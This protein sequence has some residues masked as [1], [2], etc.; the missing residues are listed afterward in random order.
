[1]LV[2]HQL[3][4]LSLFVGT[5]FTPYVGQE[6]PTK[7]SSLIHGKHYDVITNTNTNI[8]VHNI[9]YNS[10]Q[11]Q[12]SQ[13]NTIHHPL[14]I[15]N[16]PTCSSFKEFLFTVALPTVHVSRSEQSNVV[17]LIRNSTC[18]YH[19]LELLQG[20]VISTIFLN[21]DS[22]LLYD[23]DRVIIYKDSHI[24]NSSVPSILR[25]F[26]D[27][28]RQQYRTKW[29]CREQPT[30]TVIERDNGDL[31]IAS[32]K[33]TTNFQRHINYFSRKAN[34]TIN[35]VDLQALSVSELIKTLHHTDVLMGVDHE[36][37]LL[38]ALM[39]RPNVVIRLCVIECNNATS[40]HLD[41]LAVNYVNHIIDIP[42][43]IVDGKVLSG[44]LRSRFI[45]E[46]SRGK[47]LAVRR[48]SKE[49]IDDLTDGFRKLYDL[50]V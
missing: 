9:Q 40:H 10:T 7:T 8:T 31:S 34:L 22:F 49:F 16:G 47:A 41:V 12:H 32:R 14:L 21:N 26:R 4:L 29:R 38:A 17:L 48:S 15:L 30:V 2:S 33:A 37:L 5:Y 13:R 44:G 19:Y 11:Y 20:F 3:L 24:N 23:V 35:H 36:D 39:M 45:K 46:G 6:S 27:V 43:I 1:M 50:F 28:L 25:T 42:N 18:Y